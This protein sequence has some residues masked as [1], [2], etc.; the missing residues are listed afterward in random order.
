MKDD[1]QHDK[2]WWQF[3]KRNQEPIIWKVCGEKYGGEKC[4]TSV[5]PNLE[6]HLLEGYRTKL[7]SAN[8]R[9]ENINGAEFT[10]LQNALKETCN[11]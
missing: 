3:W 4:T 10:S 7:F 1:P 2:P 9:F 5:T 8:I 6:D 11:A